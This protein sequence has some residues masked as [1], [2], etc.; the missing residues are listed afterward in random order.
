MIRVTLNT[1]VL[2]LLMGFLPCRVKADEKVQSGNNLLSTKHRVGDIVKQPAF[3]GFGELLLPWD[4][5]SKYYD[6]RL[7]EVGTLMPYHSHVDAND[8]VVAL[9][10][11]ITEADSGKTIFYDFYSEQQKKQDRAKR[12][13]GLFFFRGKPGAPFAIVCPGGGFKYV[14]SLHEGFPLALE[15]SRKGF[16]AFVIRY[17]VEEQ[18]ATED[19]TAA[20]SYVFKNAETLGVATQGY[21]LWGASAGGRMVGNIALRGMSN[22]GGAD[23]PRPATV[24]ITYTGQS[25][26]S[27]DF[28]PA[29]MA[30]SADDPI[31]NVPTMD[32]RVEDLKRDGVEVDYR[33][34]KNAGHG[35][36]LG[37]GSD[38]DGWIE[39]AIAFWGKHHQ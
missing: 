28:P 9:N 25:G 10:H 34:F 16:N 13:T 11:L 4:D 27:K 2:L 21:S 24:V 38:A 12:A 17:R 22:Y 19:L 3:K 26:S 33:P 31:V 23:L 36:G 5:N 14:G 35:F 20:V 7:D 15:I 1:A 8:V 39:Q 6:T 30:V 18:A 32:K 29:F 37:K